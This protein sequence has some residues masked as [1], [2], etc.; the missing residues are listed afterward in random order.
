MEIAVWRDGD[1]IDVLLSE[2]RHLI[3]IARLSG[4]AFFRFAVQVS[5]RTRLVCSPTRAPTRI[6]ADTGSRPHLLSLADAIE[7]VAHKALH[8]VP[9]RKF[10]S[11]LAVDNEHCEAMDGRPA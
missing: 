5:G 2:S 3:F 8:E 4:R 10:D 7:E 6:G 11:G 1:K 9:V